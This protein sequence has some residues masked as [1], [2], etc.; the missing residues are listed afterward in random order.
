MH[1]QPD[2]EVGVLS[3]NREKV[4]VPLFL[5]DKEAVALSHN[6]YN[7][8]VALK[9]SNI[10]CAQTFL[11]KTEEDLNEAFEA[12]NAKVWIRNIGLI[13]GMGGVNSQL[14]NIYQDV[15]LHGRESLSTESSSDLLHGKEFVILFDMFH[16]AE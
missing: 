8:L 1:P 11:I 2:V 14:R 3:A 5:P 7:L 15:I 16:Q 13:I 6:K 12:I 4:K 9:K 10:P